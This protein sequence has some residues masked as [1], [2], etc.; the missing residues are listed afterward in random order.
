MSGRALIVFGVLL[1]CCCFAF[2]LNPALDVNQYAHTAWTIRDGFFKGVINSIAQTPD[3]Y[4]WLGTEFGLLRFDGVRTVPWAPPTGE[5]LPSSL[6]TRLL[7]TRDGRLWIATRGGLASWKNGKLTQYPE[8]G[9]Q[10]VAALLEDHRGAVWA[11]GLA[12]P[13]ARLCAIQSAKVQCYGADGSFGAGVLSLYEYG[14]SLWAGAAT[15]LWR[16]TDPPKLYPLPGPLPELSA[17]VKGDNGAL[18]MALHGGIS[19]LV[20]GKVQPYPLPSSRSFRPRVFLRD[21]EGDLW[22]GTSGQGLL[23]VHQGTTD[24]FTSADGLSSD[25]ISS[26]FEDCEGNI[27][28]GTDDGLDRFRDFAVPKISFKQGLSNVAVSSVLAARDGSFW[29][30]TSDGLNRW[31]N[32]QI[33]IYRKRNGLPDDVLESL[34][35]DDRGRI[36]VSTLH[37]IAYFEDGRFT[38]VSSVPTEMVHSIAEGSAG[39]LWIADLHQGLFHLLEGGLVEQIPWARLGRQNY[40]LSA[41]NSD[42]VTGG[43]WLGFFQ[44]GLTY[45][46]DG[47][48]RASYAATDGL[49]NGTVN[50]LRLDREGALWAATDGGLSRLKDGRIT[51]LT[52]QNGLPCD[53]AQWTIED[54]DQ[55]F[56]LYMACGLVRVARSELDAW[57]TDPKHAITATVFDSSDGVRSRADA[58]GYSPRVAKSPDGK[59]WFVTYDGVSVVDPRHLSINKRPPPVHIEQIT[60]DRKTYNATSRL[61]LPPLV[62]D[63]EIDYT[64]LSLV[65][66]EKIHFKYKLEGRDGDWQD[67]GNRR[68]AFYTDLPPRGYRFRVMASNN[69]GVWNEAGASFDFS[70]ALAYYQTTWFRLSCGAAVLMLVAALY[71]LRLRYLARQFNM[72]LEERVNERTRIARDLHDTLLQSFQG[73]S[74]KLYGLTFMI[75]DRPNEAKNTLET[76]IEQARQAISE[77]RNAVQG[78]RSSTVISNDLAQA[79]STFAK[80]LAAPE[81]GGN[82]P[83]FR[84]LVEG[85]S[86]DLAPLVRDEVH[87]VACEA[88]RNAFRHAHATRIEVEIQYERRHLR[89]RVGDNGRGIDAKVLNEGGRAGHHGLPG[90][91]ER[92]QLVGSKLVVRSKLNSGTEIELTL[93]AAL[94]YA[95][96][97]AARRAMSAGEGT[98]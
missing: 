55:S 92:A 1:T 24:L 86:R 4:L 64:A 51:T 5:H 9:G 23:H 74:M 14:D 62:R 73:L 3:G 85:E 61:R 19:Q 33:A 48:V 12:T 13:T 6:I 91:Q 50:D 45:F 72:R 78:L 41:L 76:I 89:L 47:Q 35:Q 82:C 95:Q 25:R 32:G 90:M 39:N 84:L 11:G 69:S 79:I 16:W 49:G 87:R 77:G 30:G 75:P 20:D 68:Q 15:G 83:E 80:N 10:I 31:K 96:S 42:R 53:A 59:L 94:A 2:A 60:A 21:R 98:G 54:N 93:P 40:W 66:P 58:G 18:W 29:L 8:L 65:A 26:L 34:G 22:I 28:V 81:D 38:P 27:W 63:L 37:G 7:V 57:V 44:G 97:P 71:R 36:W 56:W 43:L 17:L 70:V 52:S 46:K 88:L 67:A